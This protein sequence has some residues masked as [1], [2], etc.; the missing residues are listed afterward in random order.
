MKLKSYQLLPDDKWTLN[1]VNTTQSRNDW[2]DRIK[3]YLETDKWNK[4]LDPDYLK[5]LKDQEKH[6]QLKNSKLYFVDGKKLK[7]Y[8]PKSERSFILKRY[9]EYLGHL[10]SASILPLVSRH[11]YWP[12]LAADLKEYISK[13]PVCQLNRKLP[14]NIKKSLAQPIR[15]I[16]PVALP[17]ERW[18]LDFI[19][20]LQETKSG[21]KHIITAIDYATRWPIAKAV[22]QMTKEAVVTFI[23]ENIIINYGVPLEIITD[24]GKSFLAEAV[25]EYNERV[26]ISHL[27]STP[28]H[29]ETNGMVE[30]M[31][32]TLGHAITTMANGRRDR[33]DEFLNQ[34]LFSVRVRTHSVTNFTPFYLLYGI[35][36][37][38]PMDPR[39]P[40]ATMTNLD[41]LELDELRNNITIRELEELGQHRASAYFR[42]LQQVDKMLKNSKPQPDA[43]NATHF[44]E[45]GDMVKMKHHDKKKFEFQWK[46]PYHIV[47]LGHPG[48]YWVMSPRGEVLDSSVNQRDLAPWLAATE[49]NKDYFYDG[50][51]RDFSENATR[52]FS[53]GHYSDSAQN[54]PS[55]QV[56]FA[57]GSLEGDSVTI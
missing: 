5:F 39:P 10:A 20:N 30:R 47:R 16:P 45:E 26:G 2:P 21:N 28:Y 14:S 9:H 11:W 41:D 48:T 6:F 32:S 37:R 23:Y 34:A 7:L 55:S 13:C 49:D 36:P 19:Q 52:E 54:E 33:W 27:P 42:S 15:P 50:T 12:S 56:S 40:P 18:G 38:L 29:P 24:R 53:D 3:E 43:S 44:F 17:F 57:L 31:H 1:V 4:D 46:G 51:T 8:V 35:E 22:P 25:E